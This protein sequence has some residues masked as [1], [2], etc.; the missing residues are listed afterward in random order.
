MVMRILVQCCFCDNLKTTLPI[1]IDLPLT[2]EKLIR[3]GANKFKGKVTKRSAV[4]HGITGS[5]L[6]DNAPVNTLTDAFVIFAPRGW[7][8][9]TQIREQNERL[10]SCEKAGLEEK[11]SADATSV[12][13]IDAVGVQVASRFASICVGV[14]CEEIENDATDVSQ[15]L[16]VWGYN[17]EDQVVL[18]G[19]AANRQK[20]ESA[21]E[22]MLLTSNFD[23]VWIFISAHAEYSE[24]SGECFLV[25]HGVSG[26]EALEQ[27]GISL[28]W[29]RNCCLQSIANVCVVLDTCYSGAFLNQAH[30][31]QSSKFRE[32]PGR[33]F[34]TSS[35]PGKV[36]RYVEGQRNSVFTGALLA[37]IRGGGLEALCA[38]ADDAGLESDWLQRIDCTLLDEWIEARAKGLKVSS[39]CEL[40][41]ELLA[42]GIGPILGDQQPLVETRGRGFLV[43]ECTEQPTC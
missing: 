34:L 26:V 20:I 15:A 19:E 12:Q 3:A 14:G 2:L 24:A 16:G 35:T 17:S 28:R 36:S 41:M 9:A 38:D 18:V 31:K 43:A 8:G 40:T 13:T 32:G 42:A 27:H 30:G 11:K 1:Q 6:P 4:Y 7:S 22:T 37:V 21:M 29:L 5:E 10:F 23:T 39:V 33:V 25:T